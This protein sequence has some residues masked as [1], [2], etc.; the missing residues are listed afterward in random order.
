MRNPT[1]YITA[2]SRSVAALAAAVA[3]VVA[4]GFEVVTATPGDFETTD[5]LLAAVAADAAALARADL[6]VVVPGG[7]DRWEVT[8]MLYTGNIPVVSLAEVL[9]EAG[10][11]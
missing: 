11:L 3:A 10:A 1:A 2:S 8:D 6:L 9:A 4:L 5:D 7:E